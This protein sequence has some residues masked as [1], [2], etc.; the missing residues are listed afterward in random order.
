MKATNL[1]LHGYRSNLVWVWRKQLSKA[2][3][4]CLHLRNWPKPT[5]CVIALAVWATACCQKRH[6]SGHREDNSHLWCQFSFYSG[7]F[8]VPTSSTTAKTTALEPAST[9]RID[10]FMMQLCPAGQQKFLGG[11]THGCQIGKC[12][13]SKANRDLKIVTLFGPS[14]NRSQRRM[15][16]AST[17][18]LP[19]LII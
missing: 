2:K 3:S 16:T 4:I 8:W 10:Q 11:P 17:K 19:A 9:L 6:L 7:R 1:W 14:Q 13:S 18:H 12:W 15:C 5:S